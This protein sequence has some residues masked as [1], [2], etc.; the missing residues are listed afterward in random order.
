MKG[1]L[2]IPES[3][4]AKLEGK[5]VAEIE[6]RGLKALWVK[7]NNVILEP[8]FASLNLLKAFH[9]AKY[10]DYKVPRENGIG[11]CH[12]SNEW[13]K[14]RKRNYTAGYKVE[15]GKRLD[16][17]EE[18]VIFSEISHSKIPGVKIVEYKIPAMDG[19]KTIMET[20]IDGKGN[21][22][23]K[24]KGIGYTTGN[25]KGDGSD[26]FRKTVYNGTIWT[27][28][29]L[30]AALKEAIQYSFNKNKGV[31]LSEFTGL[32]KEG[33]AIHCYYRNGEIQS[34]FFK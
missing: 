14:I 12:D 29:K 24:Q 18:V 16:E 11:G 25:L 8:D 9:H 13:L 28:E 3:E 22:V 30:E 26:L 17:V 21:K 33:Y 31:L 27:E 23:I 20:N 7:E 10:R 34:Y 5:T 32:T 6:G 2:L 1:L 19:K 4:L 15:V